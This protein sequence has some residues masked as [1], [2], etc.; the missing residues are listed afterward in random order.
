[1]MYYW[2]FDL[3]DGESAL[4]RVGSEGNNVPEIVEV[5][6]KKVTITV[7]AVMRS[8]EVRIGE[9]AARSASAAV[10]SAARFKRRFL[11]AQ[12]DSAALIRDFSA[13]VFE[14]L[15]ASGELSGGEKS[16]SVY[17]GC[18]AGWD[19]E[20]RGRYQRIF[21]TIGFPT[22]KVVSESR[23]V[24]VGAI[25]SNSVRDHV[26][27]RAKSVLV[28]DI[29]SSTTDFAYIN[30]GKE[31]EIRTGGEVALGGGVM[32]EVL[33]DACI[34]ASPNAA[35]LRRVMEESESWKVDCEL[36]ARKL[37]EKYYSLPA[38]ERGSRDCS[39]SLMITYDEPMILD[40]V[41]NRKTAALLTEKPCPQ[42]NGQS[43]RKVFCAGLKEVR[44][45]IGDQLPELLFLT[46]GVSR[47]EEIRS[48]CQEVF[49]EA[50]IYTD[51][52]PEFSVARGLAWCGRIDHELQCFRA[53][54]E[55]LIASN[56]VE[57]IVSSRLNDL[58]L[59]ALKELL[60]P[61]LDQ[62]V[63]PVLLDWRS[64]KIE[65][66]K[67]MEEALQ[68]RIK[69]YLYSEQAKASLYQPVADWLLQIS[70][71][72]E[73]YTS[74][75]CRRY[76]VPDRSLEI[77]SV[78]S[79]SDFRILERLEARDVLSGDTLTWTAVFVE[80]IISFLVAMLCGG[81]GVVLISEG[82]I[83]MLIGFILS[84]MILIVSHAM[85]RK[86]ID[87]KLMNANLPL[88]I[89]RIALS[90]ALPHIDMPNLGIGD[91]LKNSAAG[92]L[93]S[94]SEESD[95]APEK[96]RHLLPRLRWSDPDGIS[97][98]RMQTIRSK[99]RQNC[100]KLLKDQDN[101]D[102][103]ALN[104]RMSRDISEQIETRLKEL[105]EQVEIPL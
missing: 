42:L 75:I 10:R 98:R 81:S 77:S 56:T 12:S 97:E 91:S 34:A 82:P 85:G 95:A 31:A 21:E 89:R 71:E 65:R 59:S 92:R 62:A 51:R 102:L 11:D 61:L 64:G 103:A 52:E 45:S 5:D 87:E 32:D 16:N 105:A 2:G 66:I 104:A 58:Y 29:G 79:A 53:D 73:Q 47:M 35:S 49:P 86:A 38:D 60:D 23:A 94:G 30:K 93:L 67:D 80:S 78:L 76:H 83:G 37:K 19:S 68:E 48:W 33:L 101:E 50:V 44:E 14:S 84:F 40:L 99:I 39:E 43:F 57:S 88:A 41:M 8:G 55:K 63:K 28:I 20:A 6:G 13:R 4:A 22:P 27:L 3:G 69:V 9:N 46:G 17:V 70:D 100:E 1:M 54:V 15:R 26:D 72:L 7:W 96:K 36:H 25:Q 90:N 18:P 24:M 74:E